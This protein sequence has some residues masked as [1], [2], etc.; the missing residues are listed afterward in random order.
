MKVELFVT[1]L[2]DGLC[3]E[4][5]TATVEVLERAGCEVVFNP[6][7][8]C[9][10]QP[11][12][13]TGLTLEARDLA[14]K[15]VNDYRESAVPI[16]VP[17]G[18]CADMLV[19]HLPELLP[20]DEDASTVSSRVT[21]LTAFLVDVLGVTDLGSVCQ[22]KAVLHY[23]CHGLRNLG[24]SDQADQ[25]LASV[26]G[27]E[28]VPLAQDRECCGFGGLFSVEMPEVS[29][30]IMNTKLDF[31]EQADPEVVVGGDI[32]C[33]LHLEGGLQRRGSTIDVKHIAEVLAEQR[34]Q[35]PAPG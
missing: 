28:R 22:A 35:L 34:P 8:T 23:S 6:R 11:A 17:S 33:L 15:F 27:L 20:D 4:V 9:C 32:S 10:G 1:C 3:P 31:I 5:G 2:V 16:V 13:N 21:E 18:S 26:A 12:F 29:A 7:Q 30:A 19:H 24:L 25:L 14:R